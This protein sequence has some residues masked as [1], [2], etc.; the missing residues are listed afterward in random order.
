M[1][2]RCK[3]KTQAHRLLNIANE[4][5]PPKKTRTALRDLAPLPPSLVCTR[6]NNLL[7]GFRPIYGTQG[8]LGS[9][10]FSSRAAWTLCP[11][12]TPPSVLYGAPGWGQRLFGKCSLLLTHAHDTK[13]ILNQ[14]LIRLLYFFGTALF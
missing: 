14:Y 4:N 9:I 5:D 2:L 1:E 7:L 10:T 11:R 3:K 12:I 13:I 8:S 6:A